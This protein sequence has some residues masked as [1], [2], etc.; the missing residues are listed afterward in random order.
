MNSRTAGDNEAESDRSTPKDLMASRPRIISLLGLSAWCGLV[1]GLLEVGTIVLSKQ[2][3]D[4]DQLYRKSRH[5]VW[6][7]P[8]TNLCIF[9]ALGLG[10]CGI[11]LAWRRRGRWFFTRLLGAITLLPAVLV[12]F[13][14]IYALAWLV[15][16]LGLAARI[17]PRLERHGRAFRRFVLYSFPA[18]VAIVAILGA[19][20]WVGDR[21]KQAHERVQP[22]PSPGSPNVLL[23]VMDTVAAGH[24]SLHGYDR[25]TSTTLIELAER[26]IRFDSAQAVSSWTLPSHA[27]MFTGRWPHELSVG[28]LTPLDGAH[29]TLAEYLGVRGYATAGFVANADYCGTDSGLSRGFTLYQDYIFPRLTA[30]KKSAL[31]DR[32][33][34]GIQSTA[35]VLENV[36]ELGRIRSDV[37]TGVLLLDDDRKAAAVVNREL[38]AWLSEREQPER[39]FFAFLN[40][41]DAHSPYRLP[42]GRNHRFGGA[43]LDTRQ[44]VLIDHWYE[45]DKSTVSPPD[46]AFARDAY[47]DCI[48]EL[49]EQ[50][51]KLIDELRRRDL[52]D[53]TWLII[54]ADHGES[55]A[56]HSN[57]F[58][59]G[60]SLYQTEVHVPLL[61]VPPGSRTTKHV[62]TETVSLRDIAATIVD[63]LGLAAGSPFPGDS[64]ARFW[65]ANPT[66]TP[67]EHAAPALAELVP[68][69]NAQVNRDSSGL[70]K[71]AWPLGALIEGEWSYIRS[72]G[73]VRQELFHLRQDAKEERNL[74]A[75]PAAR[76]TLERM[77][78]ALGHL[79]AGPLLPSRFSP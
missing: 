65:D 77:R 64:L 41:F 79:T 35:N 73:D 13:P 70:P 20:L 32:A 30:F 44:R 55:F 37:M 42:R 58:C 68:D 2:A 61:I 6:M 23:I 11:V 40:Y 54:A 49:D 69:P 7:I 4:S 71:A 50:L 67:I 52:L 74:A 66:T 36:F 25:P 12:A 78:S 17:V 27:S 47:D 26:G 31:V 51:G 28:W 14:K 63:M 39:P 72:E 22:L 59:H 48:A 5:F 53:R 16:A 75:D 10:G 21:V 24:L 57:T 15:V 76:P 60:T 19:S 43:P 1:A 33:L 46:V 3:F 62:V 29:P 18:P 8:V 56:E 34:D 38:L 9:L 45:V